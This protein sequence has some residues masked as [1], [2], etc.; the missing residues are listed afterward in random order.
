MTDRATLREG[1]LEAAL[2]HVPFDGWTAPALNRGAADLGLGRADVV[3]AFPGGAIEA[4]ALFLRRADIAMV[5]ALSG[6]DLEAM[7]VHKRVTLAVRLRLEG[8]EPY[9]EAI[10]RGLS[11]LALP[12]HTALAVKSLYRTVDAIWNAA[13]DRSTDYNFYT[14]RILLSGV[15]STTL[16]FWLD[17]ESEGRADTWAFLDRRIRDVGQVP[18]AIDRLRATADRLPDPSRLLR[19]RRARR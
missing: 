9:R 6:H 10:R 11:T 18:K 16:L 7:P 13:G 2:T 4:L 1:I 8:N 3:R 15:Y 14:K 5:E 12:Q 17:D 19:P